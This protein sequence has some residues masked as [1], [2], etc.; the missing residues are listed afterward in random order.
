MVN[1]KIDTLNDITMIFADISG[2]TEYSSKVNAEEVC[3]NMIKIVLGAN[4]VEKPICR[5]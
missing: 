1:A 2:F 4:N 5:V 3:V